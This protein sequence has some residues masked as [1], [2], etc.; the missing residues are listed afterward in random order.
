MDEILAVIR[1]LTENQSLIHHHVLQ[2]YVT[3]SVDTKDDILCVH[4]VEVSGV[5]CCLLANIL[6]NIFLGLK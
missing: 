2:L 4:T 6:R 3:F 1:F 5:Q